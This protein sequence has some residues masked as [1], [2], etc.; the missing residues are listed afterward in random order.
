MPSPVVVVLPIVAVLG[1]VALLYRATVSHTDGSFSYPLDDTFIHMAIGRTIAE[2]GVYGVTSHGFASAS[3]SVGW[4]LI[5]AAVIK[6]FGDHLLT[7]LFLNAVA[8]CGLAWALARDF[9]REGHRVSTVTRLVWVLAA[10]VLAPMATIVFVGMEHSLHILVSFALV[11]L[12]SR[13]L[14]SDEAMPRWSLAVLAFGATA[15]RY[16]SMFLVAFVV[17][18]AVLRR[19]TRAAITVAVAGAAPIV[20]FGLYSKL[21]GGLFLPNSVLLKGTKISIQSLSD[22]GDLLFGNIVH[23]VSIEPHMLAAPLAAAFVLAYAIRVSGFWSR[24]ALHLA[25]AI[26]TTFAHVSFASLNWFFR[27]EAYLVVLLVSGIGLYA[28][29]RGPSLGALVR[30]SLRG[31]VVGLPMALT[32][33]A[34]LVLGFGPLVRRTLFAAQ[35]APTAARN[36]FDQQVQMARFLAQQFPNETVAVNDVGAVAYFGR[37]PIVDLAGLVT[38][39]VARAKRFQMFRPPKAEDVERLT[40]GT[41]V[42]I[43]Y[44][45][46]VARPRT[47]TQLGR[48]R[49][50]GCASCAS[51]VV[52]IYATHPDAIPRVQAALRAFTPSLPADVY[53]EG[54]YIDLP[55]QGAVAGEHRFGPGDTVRVHAPGLDVDIDPIFTIGSDGRLPLI[56]ARPAPILGVTTAE[57]SRRVDASYA[58]T[59]SDPEPVKLTGPASLTLVEGRW[60]RFMVVGNTYRLGDMWSREPSSFAQVLE[61]AGGP[62]PKASGAPAYVYRRQGDGYVRHVPALEEPIQHLDIVV[63]P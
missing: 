55:E 27:Y 30:G 63:V 38:L 10:M 2:S 61:R 58:A 48:W 16:E 43:I 21:N 62:T 60:T 26:L 53:A 13:W 1:H 33:V 11:S 45:D 5:L 59:A 4:P 8:A 32:I 22:V 3:S 36:I 31:T 23:R 7:P 37:A 44:D 14:S 51:P 19:R 57:A 15:L 6:A 34:G 40:Q 9:D 56:K 35:I 17:G 12:A 28:V 39:E 18:L 25:L 24:G 41:D 47:W 52:S 54:I 29:E 20:L 46:W 49:I 42:A 50:D